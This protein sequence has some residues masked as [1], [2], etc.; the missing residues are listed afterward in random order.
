MKAAGIVSL[1]TASFLFAVSPLAQDSKSIFEKEREREKLNE[2]FDKHNLREKKDFVIESSEKMLQ[3]PEGE[4]PMGEF[5]IAKVPP[6]AKL[7]ILPDMEPEYFYDMPDYGDAYMICWANW[8]YVTRSED[9]RFYFSVSNHRG[10]GCQLNVYEYCPARNLVHKFIDVD[11]LLGWTE[12]T[13]TDGKIHGHMAIMPDGTLW[14][15]THFGVHPDSAWFAN[16]YRGSWLFSYNIYTH[17]AKNWGVPLVGSNLAMF[18][19]DTKRGRMVATGSLDNKVLCWDTINKKT[20][21]AGWPP[22]NWK[23]G[24]RTMLCD[25]TTGKF[26]TVDYNHNKRAFFSYDPEYN[27]FEHYDVYPPKNPHKPE[28]HRA[29]VPR[30]HT[31]RRAMD[32][33]YYW[34]GWGGTFFRF[35]PEGPE[36][37]IAEYIGTNWD[38]GRDALQLPM[39]STGRYIYYYPK[40]GNSP[41]V[42]YDV[43]TGTRKVIC[44]L[45]DYFFEKYGYY[46]GG[47]YGIEISKDNTY[48]V[49]CINGAFQGKGKTVFGHP[50]LLVVEIPEEERPLD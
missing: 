43:K 11:E 12:N 21:F 47:V 3:I 36:G 1:I 18:V 35:E 38:K 20:R 28:D 26:W 25:D 7:M 44:F 16:G 46:M 6:T 24:E 29:E 30:G 19:V 27:K 50:A 4:D 9:N 34:A 22:N 42:Q 10:Y 31:E 33:W 8:A 48:L 39:D 49:C 13:Y 23:F 41:I 5:T 2:K 14:A 17:E 45:Q 32:G 37:P 15:S 40:E